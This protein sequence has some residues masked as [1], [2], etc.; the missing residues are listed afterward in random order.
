MGEHDGSQTHDESRYQA[1]LR[2]LLAD[3]RAL[4]FMLERGMIETGVRRV[5]AEQEFFLIDAAMRPAP[6]AAEVL[7]RAEDPRLT[8]EIGRFNLEANLTPRLFGGSAL[9]DLEREIEEVLKI[10]RWSARLLGADTMLTGILPTIRLSDPTLDNLTPTA[11]YSELN[12]S[13]CL[14]KGGCFRVHIKGI[15]EMQLTHDNTMMEACNTSFQVHLQVGPEE[16]ARLYNIAQLV[17]APVLAAAANSPVLLGYRLWEETRIALFQHSVD[18]RSGALQVRAQPTRVGFGEKWVKE[19]VMEI[20][21]DDVTRFRVLMASDSVEDPMEVL[22]R[23]EV[24]RLSALRLHNGTVWRWNRPCYGIIDGRPHLRIENR[25]LPWGPTV[26][27]EVA[28]GAFF[29]GLVSYFG[30]EKLDVAE[31]MD[32]DDAK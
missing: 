18:A 28:N 5:G 9:S 7:E 10:A 19:S 32:F 12:R 8:T 23:G 27:D 25:A 14:Q 30:E 1:F 4:E 16:F 17:T 15:D 31:M 24:P 2:A 3:L 11:R 26:A 29:L 6:L 21:R 22:D 20:L 13:L